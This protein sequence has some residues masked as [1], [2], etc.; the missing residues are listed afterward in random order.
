LHCAVI[1]PAV[2]NAELECFNELVLHSPIKLSYH[3][4]ALFG[5]KSLERVSADISSIIILGSRSSV[6]DQLPWQDALA[7]WITPFLGRGVPTL[8]ICFGHQF[9]AHLHGGK[10]EYLHRDKS[11]VQ[12]FR[13]VNIKGSRLWP[14]SQGELFGS[15]CE[16]VSTIPA[17]FRQVATADVPQIEALEHETL[18]IFSI[19]SHPEAIGGFLGNEQEAKRFGFGHTLVKTF[20]NRK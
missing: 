2:V 14:D 20:L 12:G 1:D 17:G 19:Q 5:V 9:L 16:K 11:K 6:H 10:V 15:H 13:K 18:P 3:L 8:G 4:P 7:D